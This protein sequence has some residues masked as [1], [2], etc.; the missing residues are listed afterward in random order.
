MHAWD[1]SPKEAI[2]IQ[3]TLAENLRL[4][5]DFGEI[6]TVA[7]V[8]VGFEEDNTVT[9]AAVVVLDFKTLEPV[10]SAVARLPTAF[11]YVP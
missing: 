5:D 9:R 6:Q 4:E 11:P 1:V 10:T 8:D 7:G 3:K 2:A